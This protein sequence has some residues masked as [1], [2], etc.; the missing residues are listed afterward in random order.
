MKKVFLF[1]S[2]AMIC[3][4]MAA[5]GGNAEATDTNAVD[6]AAIEQTEVAEPA[7]CEANNDA[8]Q[9]AID[10]AIEKICGSCTEKDMTAC[11]DKII[12]ESFAEFAQDADFKAAVRE[13]VKN[14]AAQKVKEVA[15]EKSKE[16]AKDAAKKGLDE[17]MK[18][19]KK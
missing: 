8:R 3:A 9:Q 11:L 13:G 17:G 1:L 5:C 15:V 19:L 18:A 10:A 4:V 7:C 2:S 16:V 6:S 12:D 14:C